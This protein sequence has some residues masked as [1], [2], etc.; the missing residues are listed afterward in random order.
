MVFGGVTDY[1][2]GRSQAQQR[3]EAQAEERQHRYNLRQSRVNHTAA[4]QHSPCLHS[5]GAQDTEE[6]FESRGR[7]QE[8]SLPDSAGHIS[9]REPSQPGLTNTP[10]VYRSAA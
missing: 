8:Y 10:G 2:L 6:G 1:L 9:Q 7:G 3:R 4:L 5:A